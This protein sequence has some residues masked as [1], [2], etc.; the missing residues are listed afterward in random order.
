MSLD[1][2]L[3]DFAA[4]YTKVY[5]VG[6]EGLWHYHRELKYTGHPKW[7]WAENFWNNIHQMIQ[8]VPEGIALTSKHRYVRD[9]RIQWDENES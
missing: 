2:E 1:Q 9:Y 3:D 4:K 5:G 8:D 6:V 7:I